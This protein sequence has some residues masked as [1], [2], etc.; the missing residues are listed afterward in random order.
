[1]GSKNARGQAPVIRAAQAHAERK[2][3]EKLLAKQQKEAQEQ[4]AQQAK[5]QQLAQEKALARQR[6]FNFNY[7]AL[8]KHSA[9]MVKKDIN[10]G[11]VK[12]YINL[13]IIHPKK[14]AK[15]VDLFTVLP[16]YAELITKIEFRLV[17]P[18]HHDSL[19][20]YSGRVKNMMK[21][22]NC[23][24]KFDIDEFQFVVSLNKAYN[25][26]QM[27][28]AAAVFGLNFKDWTMATEVLHVKGRFNVDIGSKW[29]HRLACLYKAD[30]LVHK[31]L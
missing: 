22:I 28:L 20:I 21:T 18:T 1:M 30:F 27:K 29:D 26:S 13:D 10:T 8:P 11:T 7:D 25:L 23:L 12:L 5:A 4:L 9:L 19:E 6:A 17:A 14:T 15:D 31:E 3:A 24:N 2:A 16:K